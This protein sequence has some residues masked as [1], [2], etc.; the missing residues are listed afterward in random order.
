VINPVSFFFPHPADVL[1]RKAGLKRSPHWP[2][3][4]D[5]FLRVNPA[6]AVCG[7]KKKLEVHHVKPFHLFPHLELE[8]SNLIALCEPHHLL[9]GHLC[10]WGS[11]NAAV[12]DDAAAWRRKIRERP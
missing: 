12:S 11:Y 10:H 5:V 1:A 6:C 4:R 2:V 7:T 8:Q 9:F 3:T